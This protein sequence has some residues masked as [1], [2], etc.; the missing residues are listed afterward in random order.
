[1]KKKEVLKVICVVLLTALLVLFFSRLLTPTWTRWNNDNTIKGFYNEKKDRL[2]V[3]F[4]GTSQSLNGIS[5]MELY[6]QYGICAYNLSGEQQ[7]LLASYYW[8]KEAERLHGKTLRTVVLDLSFVFRDE[9]ISSKLSMNEKSLTHMRF[10]RVKLEAYR[11]LAKQ[12]GIRVVDYIVPL[13]RYHSRWSSVTADDFA[14]L[15]NV[16]NDF[17][18]R[19]QNAAFDMSRDVKKASELLLPNYVITEE[20][21][22]PQEELEALLNPQN[23]EYVDQICSFCKEKGLDLVFIKIA[24]S[25]TDAEHDA[26]QYLA[27]RYGIPLI[28]FNLVSVQEKIGLRFPFDYSDVT[29]PNIAGAQKITNYIGGFIRDYSRLADVRDNPDYDYLKK[30][31]EQYQ[32]VRDA[33]ALISGED[34]HSYL[35]V[36]NNSRYSVLVSVKGDAATGLMDYEREALAEL[37]FGGLASIGEGESYV[38]VRSRGTVLADER[39]ETDQRLLLDG[40]FDKQ[41]GCTV[42]HIYHVPVNS[43]GYAEMPTAS[44][45]AGR[46]FITSGGD[47]AGDLSEIMLEGKNCS[48]ANR[49]INIVV[50]DHEL[51]RIVD[52]S[53]FYTSYGDMVRTDT[54][55]PYVYSMRQSGAELA[56]AETIGDY[57]YIGSM[58]NDC[59]V[60]LCGTMVW[61]KPMLTEDDRYTFAEYGIADASFM[62][63]QPFILI[64]RD[65]TVLLCKTAGPKALLEAELPGLINMSAEKQPEGDMTVQIGDDTYTIGQNSIFAIAYNGKRNCV[66][67]S[68]YFRKMQIDASMLT[69]AEL[70]AAETIGDYVGIGNLAD[71]CTMILCGTMAWE[72]PMLTEND[73]AVFTECGVADASFIE[74][75]PFVLVIR[76]GKVLLCETV[77]PKDTLTAALS[78]QVNMTAEKQP[79]GDMTVQIGDETYTIGK[80]CV[81]AITYDEK[82][83]DIINSRYFRKMQADAAAATGAAM[84]GAKTIGEYVGIGNLTNGCTMVLCGTMTWEKP[85]LTEEDSAVFAECGVADASFMER[86]PFVLVIRD[87]EVKL[88]ETVSPKEAL[89]AELSEQIRLTAEK[90]SQ[91]DMVVQIGGES[92]TIGKNCVFAIAYDG[93]SDRILNTRYFR[94][95]Q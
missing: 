25:S 73:R 33:T 86:Q 45:A 60:I 29:H 32:P 77:G 43:E 38:G 87:G 54:A 94:K 82:Q 47:A 85:M 46:F 13:I 79:E 50:Y 41:N 83:N 35:Q 76:D 67:N 1:M 5:P 65:G 12:Y 24:K 30:Q 31:D 37:G 21:D 58:S 8:I 92:F 88:C 80:N 72:K 19:G 49:G 44:K 93:N 9:G 17:Y 36:L 39:G 84:T 69:G 2:Q 56:A 57:A 53:C 71:D 26:L 34:F 70:D 22:H 23:V 11:A 40:G 20:I 16:K 42:E 27:N 18:T 55:L 59:T 10:S 66:M 3:V 90:P 61:D 89:T 68:R 14:G 95:M 15:T 91:E 62:E 75:Q 6:H 52:T 7:P 81:F 63:R 4:V 48:D 78:G 64:I 28:D 74:R 51:E